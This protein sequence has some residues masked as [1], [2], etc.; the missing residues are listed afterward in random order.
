LD[1]KSKT[2]KSIKLL[3]TTQLGRLALQLASMAVLARILS[4]SDYGMV[5]MVMVFYAFAQV[6]TDFGLSAATVRETNISQAQLSTLFWANVG[7]GLCLTVVCAI[8][9]PLVVWFYGEPRLFG[10]NLAMSF[11]FMITTLGVQHRAILQKEMRFGSIVIA[12]L[13]ALI[14]A[15]GVAIYGASV[16][17]GPYSL[18]AQFLLSQSVRT[19][20]YLVSTKWRPGLPE[21]NSGIK[22]MVKFGGYLTATRVLNY[23]TRNFDRMII[24]RTFGAE[25]T[26]YYSRAQNLILFPHGALLVPIEQA[27]YPALSKIKD[28]KPRLHSAFA[29]AVR[30]LVLVNLPLICVLYFS[31]DEIVA[32]VYGEQWENAV[33]ILKILCI[34]GAWEPIQGAL[35]W[36]YKVSG[37]TDKVFKWRLVEVPFV[38]IGCFIGLKW[39][40]IGVA[41]GYVVGKMTMAYP[42]LVYSLK[43]IDMPTRKIIEQIYPLII[44]ITVSAVGVIA[45]KIITGESNK[46]IGLTINT[47]VAASVYI[48][49][50]IAI[51]PDYIKE[52]IAIL[53]ERK[54]MK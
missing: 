18:V 17:W 15:N 36:L 9:S 42:Y 8:A 12:D 16:G 40:A 1:L 6:F 7:L 34:Y 30:Y 2:V 37:K 44:A 51:R 29:K 23:A 3:V 4:P 45:A 43:T 47:V 48:L 32:I 54:K 38:M 46:Y 53:H 39:G 52:A 25:T 10:I 33:P 26:G 50:I 49:M 35:A 13:L 19:S 24:G 14:I 22:E 28:D 20:V 31:A 41:I 11:G 5:A 27:M 21:R